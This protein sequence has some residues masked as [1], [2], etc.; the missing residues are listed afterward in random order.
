MG[1]TVSVSVAVGRVES[2]RDYRRSSNFDLE[3]EHALEVSDRRQLDL[4]AGI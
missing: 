4:N 2:T 3:L 1:F